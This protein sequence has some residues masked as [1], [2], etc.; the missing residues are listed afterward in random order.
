MFQAEGTANVETGVGHVRENIVV[1]KNYRIFITEGTESRVC[2]SFG[3]S[4]VEEWESEKGIV[5]NEIH[6]SGVWQE[7]DHIELYKLHKELEFIL[8]K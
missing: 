5:G 1:F 7:P 6:K 2:M 3:E 4:C 8:R